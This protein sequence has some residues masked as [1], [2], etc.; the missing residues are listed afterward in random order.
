[1]TLPLTMM[2]P[3]T[4]TKR[5][6]R[7]S[8]GLGPFSVLSAVATAMVQEAFPS[9]KTWAIAPLF[10][11]SQAGARCHGSG[12]KK[13]I[14]SVANT[15]KK[16]YT[17]PQTKKFLDTP[18]AGP[19]KRSLPKRKGERITKGEKISSGSW[20]S[21][22]VNETEHEKERRRPA[23]NKTRG[24]RKPGG[25]KSSRGPSTELSVWETEGSL[26]LPYD[27]E[28]LYG[29]AERV[30]Y[31]V[32]WF[33]GCNNVKVIST[34][35]ISDQSGKMKNVPET[36][37]V[38]FGERSLGPAFLFLHVRTHRGIR[39]ELVYNPPKHNKTERTEQYEI[40]W[41]FKDKRDS[42]SAVSTGPS[43]VIGT[44]VRFH[45][46]VRNNPKVILNCEKTWGRGFDKEDA[47]HIINRLGR[48]AA[49]IQSG[50]TANKSVS[51]STAAPS[52]DLEEEDA[53]ALVRRQPARFLSM[54]D[55]GN[56]LIR[57]VK[58]DGA[59]ENEQRRLHERFASK[60]YRSSPTTTESSR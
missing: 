39:F 15:N 35:S 24:D 5:C 12:L 48:R 51:E 37:K 60:D 13:D 33:P 34:K 19:K 8:K 41:E 3:S 7:V 25:T 43:P 6:L 10:R 18:R 57:R 58:A 9:T 17:A 31:W 4:P 2:F 42:S 22:P 52:F 36:V 46:R 11:F 49:D 56:R 55:R 14:Q 40:S 45:F 50:H 53:W 16:G 32:K 59:D 20:A 26:T 47:E 38:S 30:S 27:R 1:M 54:A 23:K 21:R 29:I 44:Q 28:T